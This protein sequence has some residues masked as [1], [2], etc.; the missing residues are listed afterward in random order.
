M[1]NSDKNSDRQ[2]PVIV[3]GAPRSGT[4]FLGDVLATH[5]ELNYLIEPNP[6]WKRF[7][8]GDSDYLT[9]NFSQVAVSK[10]RESFDRSLLASGKARLLEKTPQNC[11]RFPFVHAVFP[12]AKFIHIIRNGEESTFSI[13]KFWE[14]NTHGFTGVRIGQRLREMNLRQAPYY[15]GQFVKR[16]LPSGKSPRVFWG[17][18][19]PGM[20]ELLEELSI[21]EVAAL[22]WRTCVELACH[23]GRSLPEDQYMELKL[24]SWGPKEMQQIIDFAGLTDAD[25]VMNAFMAEYD[26]NKTV[27]RKKAA[28]DASL[29]AIR[30]WINST[31]QWLEQD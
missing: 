24:E 20:K 14:T 25:C 16:L 6:M 13:A 30:P 10:T 22:Q 27:H 1:I 31:M 18:V 23:Y 2:T 7:T 26:P 5:P 29:A 15:A 28:S 3:I 12:E 17:P 21:P 4:T 11:L 9:A 8:G 19:L